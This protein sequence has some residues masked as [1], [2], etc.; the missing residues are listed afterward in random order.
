MDVDEAAI[1]GDEVDA[2]GG[3]TERSQTLSL[4]DLA[5]GSAM[6]GAREQLDELVFVFGEESTTALVSGLL[7]LPSLKDGVTIADDLST[8]L[9]WWRWA[10]PTLSP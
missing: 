3:S 10:L 9:A 5:V 1:A 2:P 6:D 7:A 4:M 8:I